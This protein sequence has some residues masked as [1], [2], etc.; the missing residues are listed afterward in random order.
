MSAYQHPSGVGI[1]HPHV[2]TA[3]NRTFAPVDPFKA[4]LAYSVQKIHPQNSNKAN[5]LDSRPPPS[6]RIHYPQN[7]GPY[8]Q[9]YGQPYPYYQVQPVQTG[10]V[11]AAQT[12]PPGPSHTYDPYA[13]APIII[14]PAQQA[15][16]GIPHIHHA[17]PQPI[18][19][20]ADSRSRSRSRS[21]HRA[22]EVALY[23]ESLSYASE[24]HSASPSE[25]RH[26]TPTVI[27]QAGRPVSHRSRSA[28]PNRR[29]RSPR[30]RTPPIF[31]PPA[32]SESRSYDQGSPVIIQVGRSDS[33]SG[34][35]R[36]YRPRRSRTASRSHR[37][38]IRSRSRSR[39]H[40]RSP[41]IRTRRSRS[42]RPTSLVYEAYRPPPE[43]ARASDA[44]GYSRSSSSLIFSGDPMLVT[45]PPVACYPPNIEEKPTKRSSDRISIYSEPTKYPERPPPVPTTRDYIYAFVV[46]VIPRQ[47]Y[48]HLL[49]R[50]PYLYFSRVTRIFEEAEM[51]MPQ[52]KQ[53]ILDA[54]TQVKDPL[55]AN[56]YET[57]NLP[58][59]NLEK[60][61]GNFIDS[62]MREWKTLNIISVLLLS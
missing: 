38:D 9:T 62:L 11:P 24:S 2:N 35:Y 40:S 27:V 33:E 23:S 56:W 32:D 46:D 44:L 8:G 59:G 6:A 26:R 10:Y 57:Q 36:S 39:R 52:I 48:L 19:V 12:F 17:Q 60:T 14:Q 45:A 49:L 58:Y 16:A 51:T 20:R 29:S 37:S 22:P 50:L 47:I 5:D 30:S 43:A 3:P 61:W 21:R 7:I 54:A 53:G 34:R 42:P 41:V 15:P 1:L 28:S 55:H 4:S 25:R 31:M 18:I 13:P